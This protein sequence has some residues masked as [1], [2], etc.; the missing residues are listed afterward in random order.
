[1]RLNFPRTT[2]AVRKHSNEQRA[3]TRTPHL[4]GIKKS[5]RRTGVELKGLVHIRDEERT[6]PSTQKSNQ[7]QK[8]NMKIQRAGRQEQDCSGSEEWILLILLILLLIRTPAETLLGQEEILKRLEPT[9]QTQTQLFLRQQTGSLSVAQEEEEARQ[10]WK[11]THRV[12]YVQPISERLATSVKPEECPGQ[13]QESRQTHVFGVYRRDVINTHPS[14][15]TWVR[16][17]YQNHKV[18]TPQRLSVFDLF[19]PWGRDVAFYGVTAN[20]GS[21]GET[22]QTTTSSED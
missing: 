8:G 4:S 9:R 20:N 12:P 15:P 11:E 7:T 5:R 16:V 3:A 21:S 18:S 13:F 2:S 22:R 10:R 1:M 14:G 19:T 6:R 17:K